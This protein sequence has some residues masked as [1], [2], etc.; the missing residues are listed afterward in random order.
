MQKVLIAIKDSSSLETFKESRRYSKKG[1]S[2][3]NSYDIF[4]PLYNAVALPIY[5]PT[6]SFKLM[7]LRNIM[8]EE[9]L[10]SKNANVTMKQTSHPGQSKQLKRRNPKS[11]VMHCEKLSTNQI[12]FYSYE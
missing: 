9:D 10:H 5:V 6:M 12:V 3:G 8:V 4:F 11:V 1:K 2:E 7:T